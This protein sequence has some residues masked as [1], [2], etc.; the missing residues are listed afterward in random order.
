MWLCR[1]IIS[2]PVTA[3]SR[4]GEKRRFAWGHCNPVMLSERF[5]TSPQPF[6]P[7]QNRATALLYYFYLSFHPL[8]FLAS[9]RSIPIRFQPRGHKVSAVAAALPVRA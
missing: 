7:L 9:E 1:A 4:Y 6:Y 2:A 5:V 3:P 8:S